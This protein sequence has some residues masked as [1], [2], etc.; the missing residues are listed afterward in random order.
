MADKVSKIIFFKFYELHCRITWFADG[1]DSVHFGDITSS[2]FANIR[3]L[4]PNTKYRFRVAARNGYCT[5]TFKNH[6]V[7]T[8]KGDTFFV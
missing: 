5:S 4:Q 6:S 8:P 3:D 1:A 7:R 2:T